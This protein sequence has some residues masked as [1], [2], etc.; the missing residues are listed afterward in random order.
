ME[1]S[2]NNRFYCIRSKKNYYVYDKYL[3][4]INKIDRDLFIKFN[5]GTLEPL[6]DLSKKFTF[7]FKI[8]MIKCFKIVLF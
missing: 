5:N 4:S 2:L 6:E 8:I 1:T 7:I 3:N